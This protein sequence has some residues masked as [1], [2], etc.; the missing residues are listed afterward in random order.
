MRGLIIFLHGETMSNWKYI[1][2]EEDLTA[3]EDS[4][5]TLCHSEAEKVN[6]VKLVVA[7]AGW[8]AAEEQ[9][10][11]TPLLFPVIMLY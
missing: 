9:H 8:E 6:V 1:S 5:C 2:K 7:K 4:W 10:L 3:E 11:V